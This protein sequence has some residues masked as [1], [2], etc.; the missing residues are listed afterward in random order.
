MK[1]LFNSSTTTLPT[2]D[3]IYAKLD[4]EAVVMNLLA[5]AQCDQIKIHGRQLESTCPNPAHPDTNPSFGINLGEPHAPYLCHGCGTKG[6][7]QTLVEMIKGVDTPQALTYLREQTHSSPVVNAPTPKATKKPEERWKPAFLPRQKAPPLLVGTPQQSD[8]MLGLTKTEYE[9]RDAEGNCGNVQTRLDWVDHDGNP[10]KRFSLFGLFQHRTM[11]HHNW[12]PHAHPSPRTLFHLDD[13]V[14]RPDALTFVAEGEK[15]AEALQSLLP[16]VVVTTSMCGADNAAQTDWSPLKDRRLIIWRDND[17]QGLRYQADVRRLALE[18]GASEVRV[19][20]LAV[21]AEILGKPLGRG[22]DVA[23]LVQRDGWTA[24]QIGMVLA[25]PNGLLEDED[26]P[27]EEATAPTETAE[28]PA[29]GPVV[30][31]FV[32]PALKSLTPPEVVTFPMDLEK[33]LPPSAVQLKA[34]M[35]AIS[36]TLQVPVEMPLTL[37]MSIVSL[38][39]SRSVE[40]QPH[41]G[42]REVA[43]LWFLCLADPGERKSGIVSLLKRGVN[44]WMEE[45]HKILRPALAKHV[46]A[47]RMAERKLETYRTMLSKPDGS[48]GGPKDAR[49]RSNMLSEIDA[50]VLQESEFEEMFAPSLIASDATPEA[51][52]ELLHKNG[53]RLGIISAEGDAV[54]HVLGRYSDKPNLGI[55]LSAHAGDEYPVHRR[56]R[57]TL[58]IKHPA[59]AVGLMVQPQAVVEMFGDADALG[60]GM[61]ARFLMTKPETWIGDRKLSPP[62]VPDD[63]L[64]WWEETIK[65][66]LDHPHPGKVIIGESGTV[67]RCTSATQV[68]TL[69]EEAAAEFLALRARIEPELKRDTGSLAS[70]H[71]WG[72]KLAGHVARIALSLQMVTDP[73]LEITGE[74]MRAAIAWADYLI[75]HAKAIFGEAALC[76]EDR[77]ALRVLKWI[78]DHQ[79]ERFSRSEG[80]QG[81]RTKAKSKAEDW[82]GAFTRLREAG[83]LRACRLKGPTQVGGRPSEGFEVN[84]A[85]WEQSTPETPKT[86]ATDEPEAGAAALA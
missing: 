42:W 63:L 58:T 55:Y 36:E 74:V 21:V 72:E 4:T 23:D 40:V 15:A 53:E 67:V 69:T 18:A 68:I 20:N 51:V 31:P 29:T 73:A 85:V 47:K 10:H 2:P 5:E 34:L 59:I 81:V 56:G 24:Q 44:A 49:E 26:P 9:Y 86:D 66:L 33:V 12:L 78:K 50:L 64:T 37:A 65:Q 43:A 77:D 38:T 61:V 7:L 54:D 83:Y 1:P 32:W 57:P 6:N 70:M 84:P 22:D 28:V 3:E 76:E 60:R 17:K 8:R 19:V 45:E 11:G 52:A 46:E 25:H 62:P 13:L 79:K 16:D 75:P 27:E 71:G 80:F 82:D 30:A 35:R 48:R 14:K 41:P 39:I